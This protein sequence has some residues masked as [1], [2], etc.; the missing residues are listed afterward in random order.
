LSDVESILIIASIQIAVAAN[1][2]VKVIFRHKEIKL[3]K[4]EVW[5]FVAD[6]EIVWTS[7]Y[8]I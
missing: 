1:S 2:S 6:Q 4:W 5:S 7:V 8:K 3:M